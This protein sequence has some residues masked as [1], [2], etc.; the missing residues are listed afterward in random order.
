LSTGID[1]DRVVLTS[2]GAGA[3]GA[4]GAPTTATGSTSP[5]VTVLG[6][7]HTSR[8]VRVEAC[9]TGCWFVF[10]EGYNVGWAA[11]VDGHSL[12]AQSQVDGGFNGWY[13]PPSTAARTITLEFEGQNALVVGLLLSGLG[14]LVCFGLIVFDRRRF[15]TEDADEPRPSVLWGQRT[16]DSPYHWRS[17][18]A[19]STVVATLAGALVIA[20]LWGLLC[21]AVA[22]LTCFV[23]GRP[24]LLGY[25]AVAI[26]GVMGAVMIRRVTSQHPFANAG[27]PG[28]F[29]DLHR[30]GLAVI[31]LLLASAIAT[32]RVPRED[33]SAS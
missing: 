4:A 7:S 11:T 14:V 12:G 21:G 3:A 8:T 20:P 15:D 2:A 24:R 16:A 27:W 13:L 25:V 23:A 19:A 32:A 26:V 18:A 29:E 1:V 5:K 17:P 33:R 28:S 10:G 22:F 6:Q 31:V 9:P 30:P